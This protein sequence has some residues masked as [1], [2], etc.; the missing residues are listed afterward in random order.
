MVQKSDHYLGQERDGLVC[1]RPESSYSQRLTSGMSHSFVQSGSDLREL[2]SYAK[3]ANWSHTKCRFTTEPGRSDPNVVQNWVP[4][5]AK[6]THHTF[7]FV[8]LASRSKVRRAIRGHKA[9]RSRGPA[10]S[11][12]PASPPWPGQTLEATATKL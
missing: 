5:R 2:C 9:S 7:C 12:E 11:P 8:E 6:F 4:I 1:S 3:S 10:F